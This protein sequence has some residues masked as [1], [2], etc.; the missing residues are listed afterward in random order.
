MGN[1]QQIDVEQR[2]RV[3]CVRLK[4]RRLNDPDLQQLGDE[5]TQLIADGCRR[6]AFSLGNDRLDCLYS[7]FLGIL[8]RARRLLQEHGGQIH[9]CEAGPLNM[10]VLKYTRLTDLFTIDTDMDAAVQAL[11]GTT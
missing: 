9:L 6:M 4:R 10:D 3:A 8:I 11:E 7:D 5:L 1:W 2:G